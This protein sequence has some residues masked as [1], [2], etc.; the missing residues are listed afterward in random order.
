V[1]TSRI[2]FHGCALQTAQLNDNCRPHPNTN[3]TI[4]TLFLS[5]FVISVFAVLTYIHY[6]YLQSRQCSSCLSWGSVQG[7]SWG[8][9]LSILVI[10]IFRSSLTL[11]IHDFH[12]RYYR[13]LPYLLGASSVCVHRD[14]GDANADIM[15]SIIECVRERVQKGA[16]TLMVKIK[17][18]RGE[19]LNELA[20]TQAW[21]NLL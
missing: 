15:V 21:G 12:V 8:S 3:F 2:S 16:R 7:V 17:E 13:T 11:H 14:S 1:N 18:Y 6:A 20:D 4:P 10:F 5:V 9:F 19:P